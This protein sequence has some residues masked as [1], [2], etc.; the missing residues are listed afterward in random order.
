M[1]TALATR[2]AEVFADK[3]NHA[4]LDDAA[5]LSGAAFTR[6]RHRPGALE[7]AGEAKPAKN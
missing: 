7:A 4:S 5:V 6:Y 2:K 3:L 1:L